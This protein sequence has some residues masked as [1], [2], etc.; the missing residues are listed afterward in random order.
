[1]WGR[2]LGV[3]RWGLAAVMIAVLPA[4]YIGP[5]DAV[6]AFG[7]AAV[8]AAYAAVPDP[9][10]PPVPDYAWMG[11]DMRGLALAV[12][13]FGHHE[14]GDPVREETLHAPI[15]IVPA[16]QACRED[17]IKRAYLTFD[18]GPTP[19]ITE[20]ILDTLDAYGIKATFFVVGR[21][22]ARYPDLA[23]LDP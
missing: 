11:L 18:D 4:L 21:M 13:A 14:K 22:A 23:A 15:P 17:G 19:A 20:A 6:P 12:P 10:V 8:K 7:V 3:I 1:M 2:V 16:E 9:G 5:P